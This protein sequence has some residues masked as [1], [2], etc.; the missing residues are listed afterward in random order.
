MSNFK[1]DNK[2]YTHYV[3]LIGYGRSGL[4]ESGWHNQEDATDLIE[5]G[6]YNQE[7]AKD[8]AREY[9]DYIKKS[10]YSDCSDHIKELRVVVWARKTVLKKIDPRF[11]SNWAPL[12]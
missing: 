9:R 1:N 11:N 5:S 12:M 2:E 10:E 8:R 4:I 6:W 3:L 7:D